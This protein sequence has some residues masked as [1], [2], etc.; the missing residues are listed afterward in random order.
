MKRKFEVA[1]L[2]R[3]LLVAF[4]NVVMYHLTLYY[5]ESIISAGLATLI[6]S[7]GPVFILILSSVV[8]RER[9]GRV[10]FGAIAL[11]LVGATILF[12]GSRNT[13]G[14]G[15]SH[16]ILEAVGTAFVYSLNAVFSKPLVQKYGTISF[17]LWTGLIGT[18]MLL[19]LL[20]GSFI[21]QV[22]DLP[23]L[24]WLAILYLSL[25]STVLGYILFYTLLNRG[26]VTKISVQLYLIPVVGVAGGAFLLGESVTLFTILGGA[27]L[28][29]SVALST[30]RLPG[31]TYKV[32]N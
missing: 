28:L 6:V 10:V 4:A 27:A 32:N 8:L 2:P 26:A 29:L 16:G 11:S 24:G 18:A 15:T 23:I 25:L 21:S 9:H 22:R 14:I 7:L 13:G 20:S 12:I 1:D 31:R 5:S 19:P 3:F 30:L 17:T